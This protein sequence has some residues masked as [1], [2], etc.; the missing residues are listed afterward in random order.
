MFNTKKICFYILH[1]NRPKYLGVAYESA[2]NNKL[3]PNDIKILDN[4]SDEES[5]IEAKQLLEPGVEWRL[6]NTNNSR[7]WNFKRCFDLHES[8]YLVG[9]HDD[10]YLEPNFINEQ[11]HYLDMH[12][13]IAALSCNGYRVNEFGLKEKQSLLLPDLPESR[14]IQFSCPEEL[15][16]HIYKGNCVPFSPIIYRR[17]ALNKYIDNILE[18]EKEFTQSG[19][20]A[21]LCKMLEFDMIALNTKPLFNSRQHPTQH[22]EQTEDR[23][24][25]KFMNYMFDGPTKNPELK[26]E[27][28]HQIKEWQTYHLVR[29]VALNIKNFN[30]IKIFKRLKNF[31]LNKFSIK[32]VTF[33][34][35]KIINKLNYKK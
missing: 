6:S 19:D 8:E 1:Y 16:I 34:F 18:T 26:N 12:P 11:I 5:I 9:F 14:I 29:D 33:S 20:A 22:S 13:E 3:N 27:L 21:F 4:N 2:I 32:G 23:Q 28:R 17:K 35:V 15:G 30:F 10:D 25:D 24:M 7:G 31:D